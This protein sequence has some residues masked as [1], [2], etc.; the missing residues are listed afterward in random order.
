MQSLNFINARILTLFY[1]VLG[2]Y[3]EQ[4]R[5]TALP[6]S[7]TSEIKWPPPLMSRQNVPESA[8]LFAIHKHEAPKSG[9]F[10]LQQRNTD[11]MWFTKLSRSEKNGQLRDKLDNIC[12]FMFGNNLHNQDHKLWKLNLV[13]NDSSKMLPSL[14]KSHSVRQWKLEQTSHERWHWA[15]NLNGWRYQ[16]HG[17]P[18]N[19]H[20]QIICTFVLVSEPDASWYLFEIPYWTFAKSTE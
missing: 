2:T 6:T 20:V 7:N 4:S 11:T 17:Y 8:R 3:P 1:L 14:T 19:I 15:N 5:H 9:Y 16:I 12:V 18:F 10:F 13:S